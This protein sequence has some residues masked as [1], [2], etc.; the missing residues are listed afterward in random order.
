M[1]SE[2]EMAGDD[3]EFLAASLKAPLSETLTERPRYLLR[4]NGTKDEPYKSM[5]R[6][7]QIRHH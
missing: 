1:I 2:T 5:S 4:L 3:D 6:R 7:R